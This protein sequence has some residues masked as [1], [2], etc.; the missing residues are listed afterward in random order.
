M[1]STKVTANKINL[2]KL[3]IFNLG[4]KGGSVEKVWTRLLGSSSSDESNGVATSSDGS[5]YITGYTSG[6]LDGETNAGIPDAFLTKYNS[7]G[8]KV[9]TRLLGTSERDFGYGVATSSDGSVYITG[10]ASSDL[11]GQ[12]NTGSGDAFLTKYNSD[13]TKAWTRLLGTSSYDQSNG[14]ATSS[15]DNIYITGHTPRDLDG[16]TNAGNFDAFLVKYSSEGAIQW[17]KL[18]G[19]SYYE[20]SRGVA[21]SS[22]GSIYITGYTRGGDLDGEINAGDYD[23]FL[24]KYYSDGAKVWTKLLGT[25]ERDIGYG[26]A[27]SSDGSIYITGYTQGDLDSQTFDGSYDAFLTKYDSNGNKAWTRQLGSSGSDESFGVATSSD[28]SI[29]ITGYTEGNLDGEI[30]AGAGSYDAFL[31]KYSSDGTKKWTK[32]LGTSDT[33]VSNGVATSSDGSIYITGYT[34]G[35]LDSETNAGSNDAFLTKYRDSSPSEEISIDMEVNVDIDGALYIRLTTDASDEELKEIVKGIFSTYHNV[36]P[37]QIFIKTIR[38]GSIITE[39]TLS[40]SSVSEINEN[41]SK[42]E[43]ITASDMSELIV[44]ETNSILNTTFTS[45]DVNINNISKKISELKFDNPATQ[46]DLNSD[47]KVDVL[48]IVLA[49]NNNSKLMIENIVNYILG[50]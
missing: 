49:F 42:I 28:G 12:T 10:I 39:Y 4:L 9:W 47:G 21:T 46:F 29:Y 1:N 20:E 43:N 37:S 6:D 25:S 26:I 14:V 38:I 22:D 30:N 7:D 31:T 36:D 2:D 34:Q 3:S 16:E 15:D 40:V 27:T 48:D 13:G 33:D 50:R 41:V 5:V 11:D 8:T 32:L 24:T 23:A 19:T 17:T 18:L 45:S 44:S 35:D